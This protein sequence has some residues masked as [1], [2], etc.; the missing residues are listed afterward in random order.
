MLIRTPLL[1]FSALAI[2]T[3]G[4]AQEPASR[5]NPAL[6][7]SSG[8]LVPAQSGAA[9]KTPVGTPSASPSPQ[10]ESDQDTVC[11][12]QIFLDEYSFGPGKI[13]GRWGEF[14]GKALHRL[15]AAQGQ[16]SSDQIDPALQQELEKISPVYTT[17]TLTDS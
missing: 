2:A 6:I 17:Y 9:A 8:K 13:D 16:K 7:K 11:R 15:Q 3:S 1:A 12:L 14:L 5:V 4:Y 10:P